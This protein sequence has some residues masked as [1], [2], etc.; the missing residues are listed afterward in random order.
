MT[1]SI[2]QNGYGGNAGPPHLLVYSKL[3]ALHA[4]QVQQVCSKAGP[5]PASTLYQ[6]QPAGTAPQSNINYKYTRTSKFCSVMSCSAKLGDAGNCD[7]RGPAMAF[8]RVK[9]TL[10]CTSRFL[11][12][13]VQLC[14]RSHDRCHWS[15]S[16]HAAWQRRGV[17]RSQVDPSCT[18][19]LVPNIHHMVSWNVRAITSSCCSRVSLVKWTASASQSM[20][21]NHGSKIGAGGV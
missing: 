15:P 3:A 5:L 6:A 7:A 11:K 8:Q 16:K 18:L 12:L 19:G 1:T 20:E 4:R 9:R 21:C 2:H 17:G 14:C 10:G 13:S